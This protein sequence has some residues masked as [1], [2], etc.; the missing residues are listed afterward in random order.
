MVFYSAV[1]K[2]LTIC[3]D[4]CVFKSCSRLL[5]KVVAIQI[6]FLMYLCT[7]HFVKIP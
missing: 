1:M 5:N 3:S 7:V 4:V 6:M 2:L